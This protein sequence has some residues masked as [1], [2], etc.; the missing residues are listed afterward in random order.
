[1]YKTFFGYSVVEFKPCN[2]F[3]MNLDIE[4]TFK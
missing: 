1:M 4:T 2:Y 3:V